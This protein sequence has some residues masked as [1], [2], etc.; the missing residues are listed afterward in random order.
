MRSGIPG[1]VLFKYLFDA[2]LSA[3]VSLSPPPLSFRGAARRFSQ[4]ASEV[5]FDAL[6][7]LE[8]SRQVSPKQSTCLVAS[9]WLNGFGDLQN[10]SVAD[11]MFRRLQTMVVSAS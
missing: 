6:D 8:V 9:R 10:P 5:D 3:E 1:F 7:V 11:S 2:A 4:G